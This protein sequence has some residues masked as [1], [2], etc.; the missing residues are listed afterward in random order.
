LVKLFAKQKE[1][2]GGESE[3]G[4]GIPFARTPFSSR[5]ARA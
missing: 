5:P 1:K 4:A 2:F 3:D